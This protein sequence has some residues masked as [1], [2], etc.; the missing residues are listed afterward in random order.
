MSAGF[1]S[2][3]GGAGTPA[4]FVSWTA[5]SVMIRFCSA[6]GLDVR[7]DVFHGLV[8]ERQRVDPHGRAPRV[9][10]GGTAGPGLE[11]L[12]LLHEVPVVELYDRG[13]IPNRYLSDEMRGRLNLTKQEKADL[14]TFMKEGLSSPDYPH[15]EPPKLP[16]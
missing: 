12:E 5:V 2:S 9:S 15:V 7:D 6:Q 3:G 14:V 4:T 13:G 11:V 10:F 8:V 16:E 1:S